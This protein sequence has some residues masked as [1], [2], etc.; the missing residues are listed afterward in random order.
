ML[1][2]NHFFSLM[3]QLN[4]SIREK[5]MLHSLALRS[6]MIWPQSPFLVLVFSMAVHIISSEINKEIT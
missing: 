4:T 5:L 1:Q 3:L 6:S 2:L